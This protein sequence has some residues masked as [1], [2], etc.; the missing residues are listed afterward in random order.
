VTIALCA[1]VC[2][3]DEFVSIAE[4]GR[5]KHKLLERFLD[6]S[7][8]IPSLL[9][10]NA[11]LAALAPGEFEKCLPS[12]ITERAKTG[13]DCGEQKVSK[14]FIGRGIDRLFIFGTQRLEPGPVIG[15]FEPTDG[16]SYPVLFCGEIHRDEQDSDCVAAR[17]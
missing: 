17:D 6:L 2:G 4:Y 10:F 12:W 13:V 9:R 11:I 5:K 15:L 3:A 7:A 1:V 8:G 14:R 16:I